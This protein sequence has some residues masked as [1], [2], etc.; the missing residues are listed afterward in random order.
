[1]T[2]GDTFFLSNHIQNNVKHRAA[3]PGIKLFKLSCKVVTFSDDSD[4]P[5]ACCSNAVLIPSAPEGKLF[6]SI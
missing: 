6:Q 3:R 2:I 5:A 1:M 4:K